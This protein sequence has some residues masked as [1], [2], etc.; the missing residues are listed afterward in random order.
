MICEIPERTK[1]VAAEFLQID[2]EIALTFA[3][4]ALT[5]S[6]EQKRRRLIRAARKAYDTI[7]R[8]RKD[9]D[10]T[11]SGRDKLCANLQR[12]KGELQ[13]LGQSF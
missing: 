6:D 4:I 1:R 10:L 11:D 7:M 9:F 3:G 13:S 2:C 8:L 5:T 12:L